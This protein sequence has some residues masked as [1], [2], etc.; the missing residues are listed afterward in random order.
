V[1][2]QLPNREQAIEFLRET[3]CPPQIINHCIA[4]ANYALE[5]ARKL[6]E[7]DIN[8]DLQLIEAGALLHDI[9]RS[10]THSVDHAIAGVEVAKNLG[11]S[12]SIV[13]IIKRHVG[14]GITPDEAQQLGWSKDNYIPQTLEE[15]IVCYA[16]KRVDNDKGAVPIQ[17]EIKRLQKAGFEQAAERVRLLHIEITNL[18]GETHD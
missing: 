14:A 13:N 6:Q 5:I 7:K 1:N 2:P 17:T 10:K 9:G 4:V 8:L 15:K 12:P 16:D 11:L 3:N 18:L